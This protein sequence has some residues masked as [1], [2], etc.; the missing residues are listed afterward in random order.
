M[1]AF[2]T[3]HP[4]VKMT[5]R[6]HTRSVVFWRSSAK[7]YNAELA[8]QREKAELSHADLRGE[9]RS[10]TQ[11]P[12]SS[13]WIKYD[14]VPARVSTARRSQPPCNAHRSLH[15]IQHAKPYLSTKQ[16]KHRLTQLSLSH[17]W[18]FYQNRYI[19]SNVQTHL[20]NYAFH[21]KV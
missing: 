12:A 19:T 8:K 1:N 11:F 3:V 10:R 13:K 17:S 16:L 21:L 6:I 9:M 5:L 20:T 14:A 15:I 7:M 4:S 18:C 2:T